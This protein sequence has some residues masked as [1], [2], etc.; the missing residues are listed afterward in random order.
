M[1]FLFLV[2]IF[3]EWFGFICLFLGRLVVFVLNLFILEKLIIFVI[4]NLDKWIVRFIFFFL[5]LIVNMISFLL[6]IIV[7]FFK[8]GIFLKFFVV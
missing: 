8:Y 5:W 7:I 4:D 2:F 6:F 1:I 3:V